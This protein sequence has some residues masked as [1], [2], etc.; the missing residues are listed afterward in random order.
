MLKYPAVPWIAPFAL[1]LSLLFLSK[2]V[3]LGWWEFPVW[4]AVMSGAI[5]F[6][7]R[8]VLDLRSPRWAQSALLGVAVFALWVAPDLLIPGWRNHWIFQNPMLGSVGASFPQPLR[9]DVWA[10]LFRSIRAAVIVPVVEE[11]FWRGWLM[12]WLIRSDFQSVPLGAY[13]RSS[14][15]FTALLFASEHGPYW[16]VGLAAGIAYN[17]WMV[18]T[19]SLGD[20]IVA[21]GVTNAV[22]SAYVI[23]TGC[24]E[25]WG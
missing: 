24:W 10:L 12:R 19:K 20:C 2:Q 13:T 4:L 11:L 6:F 15:W 18:R 22:L 9:E 23:L 7:S 1:F 25:Y 3:S 21:H 16:E 17:W 8:D 14:F 5:W